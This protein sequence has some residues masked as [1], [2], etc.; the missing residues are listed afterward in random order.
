LWSVAVELQ[1][2]RLGA[3]VGGYPNLPGERRSVMHI[4]ACRRLIQPGRVMLAICA[5]AML[6]ACKSKEYQDHADQGTFRVVVEGEAI[7]TI[8][9]AAEPTVAEMWTPF[10][11]PW[12]EERVMRVVSTISGQLWSLPWN[13]S[14]RAFVEG[15]FKCVNGEGTSLPVWFIMK[16][17]Q[18]A[19]DMR[20]ERTVRYYP[21]SGL[22]T[23]SDLWYA[24]PSYFASEKLDPAILPLESV[25]EIAERAGG[26]AFR[27]KGGEDCDL[28]V[29]IG[30][31]YGTRNWSVSYTIGKVMLQLKIDA[32]SGAVVS[33][34]Y[35]DV[36]VFKSAS[37]AAREAG[38]LGS[39]R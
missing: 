14:D 7:S 3:K 5:C 6:V 26:Q 36:Q 31:G 37:Q 15:R 30:Q 27:S 21:R 22:A 29:R 28:T 24:N 17:S 23:W 38:A 18:R 12:T 16:T 19:G 13:R 9:V 25:L 34:S 8:A 11:D 35:V 32:H 33:S 4:L 2:I 1:R 10:Q 20:V 39:K